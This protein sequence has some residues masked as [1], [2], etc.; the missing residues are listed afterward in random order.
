MTK[1]RLRKVALKV[2]KIGM[3]VGA[4]AQVSLWVHRAIHCK[5]I[6]FGI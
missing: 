1:A 4:A 3:C 5:A 6:E 2:V